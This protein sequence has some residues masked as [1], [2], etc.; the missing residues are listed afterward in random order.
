MPL[1]DNPDGK[2]QGGMRATKMRATLCLLIPPI[3]LHRASFVFSTLQAIVEICLISTR[4]ELLAAES[5]VYA[6]AE[7]VVSDK[8]GEIHV[9]D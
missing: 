1:Y 7:K 5:R 4:R 9:P 8:F 3:F 6:D 2:R